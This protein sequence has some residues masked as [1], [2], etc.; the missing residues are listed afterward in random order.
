MKFLAQKNFHIFEKVQFLVFLLFL[1]KNSNFTSFPTHLSMQNKLEDLK[2][3]IIN[4]Y[5]I[6]AAFFQS[7]NWN[8]SVYPPPLTEVIQ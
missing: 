1:K 8:S 6:L 4:L 2:F 3:Q 5:D 7:C